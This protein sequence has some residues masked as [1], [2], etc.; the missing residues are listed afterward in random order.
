MLYL[1]CK[2]HFTTCSVNT[3]V[4]FA[5][6]EKLF[7]RFTTAHRWRF[8][9]ISAKNM[10]SSGAAFGNNAGKLAILTH[11]KCCSLYVFSV[12]R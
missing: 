2:T 4:N 12:T 1:Q 9:D 6:I 10:L 7:S 8:F 11:A 5:E 3:S